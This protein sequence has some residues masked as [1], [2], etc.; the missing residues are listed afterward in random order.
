MD[1]NDIDGAASQARKNY[2]KKK[3]FLKYGVK[4]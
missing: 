4:N 1:A 2:A 3:E